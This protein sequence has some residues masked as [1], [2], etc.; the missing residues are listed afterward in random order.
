MRDFEIKPYLD[1]ILQKL[2]KKD[3][4]LYESVIRQINEVVT[5]SDIEHYKNLKYDFKNTK[6]VHISSFVLIF[7]YDKTNDFVSFIDFDH[8]DN[9]YKR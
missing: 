5:S 6:R 3:K 4:T 2:N 1:K 8:H 7:N 9:I